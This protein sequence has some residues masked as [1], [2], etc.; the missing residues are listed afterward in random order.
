MTDASGES[1]CNCPVTY[2]GPDCSETISCIS[3]AQ[4]EGSTTCRLYQGQN[5]C[6]CGKEMTG[7]FCDMIISPG[8]LG[9]L[10]HSYFRTNAC[11]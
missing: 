5:Y 7:F 11:Q 3:D 4:C 6:D 2:I 1:R 9:F 8:E 10:D